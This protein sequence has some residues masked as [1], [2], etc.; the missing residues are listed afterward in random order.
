MM[1][2]QWGQPMVLMTSHDGDVERFG[3]IEKARYWLRRRWP[4]SDGARHT[5][6]AKVESAM[7]CMSS[8]EEARRAFLVA[9]LSA[10]FAPAGAE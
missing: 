6:L 3:T 2:I 7:E 10:G 9:A 1:E 8:V 4:V 5:A